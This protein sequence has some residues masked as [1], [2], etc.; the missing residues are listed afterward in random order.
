MSTFKKGRKAREIID[1]G[2]VTSAIQ[3]DKHV[4]RAA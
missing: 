4:P 2:A 3:N 1:L